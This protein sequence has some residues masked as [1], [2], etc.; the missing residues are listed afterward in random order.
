[1]IVVHATFPIDP[2]QREEALERASDLVDATQQ[3][4]G[5][6]DYEA[7]TDVQDPNVLRFTE[8]YE[9]EDAFAAHSESEHFE[10]F[11]A[12]LPD[13]LAGEP[14]VVRF[15]VSDRTELEI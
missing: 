11:E 5:V 4:A 7:N 10:A 12:E 3:E 15:D 2:E 1:M 6:I 9:D 8:V 14:E 13:L